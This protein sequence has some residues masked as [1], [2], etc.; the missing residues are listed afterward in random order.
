MTDMPDMPR[1][2]LT[3]RESLTGAT[4]A[5]QEPRGLGPG[6]AEEMFGPAATSRQRLEAQ[7][8]GFV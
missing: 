6:E 7:R 8:V 3:A 4:P 5:G 1:E 2:T